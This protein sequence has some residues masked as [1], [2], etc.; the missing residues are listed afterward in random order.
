MFYRASLMNASMQSVN[1]NKLS[2]QVDKDDK[3]IKQSKKLG[4]NSHHT[5]KLMQES[6]QVTHS[7]QFDERNSINNP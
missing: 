5:K 2:Q 1:L 3:S 4:T 7:A 6:A